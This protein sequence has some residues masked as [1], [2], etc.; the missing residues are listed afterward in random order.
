MWSCIYTRI[1]F[2]QDIITHENWNEAV[3]TARQFRDY[4]E[5]LKVEIIDP[6]GRL[7]ATFT[8]Y[9]SDKSLL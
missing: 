3:T 7:I 5:V 4:N 8:N 2:T 6:E 1:D 9:G